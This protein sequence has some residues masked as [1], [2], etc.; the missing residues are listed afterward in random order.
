M[1]LVGQLSSRTEGSLVERGWA[2]VEGTYMQFSE[3]FDF[4]IK[5][6]TALAVRLL[7]AWKVR[8]RVLCERHG[9]P[10]QTPH[11]I[12]RLRDLV[13][14]YE[15]KINTPSNDTMTTTESLPDL[16]SDAVLSSS[17]STAPATATNATSKMDE[18]TNSAATWDQMLGFI[19]VGSISWDNFP[20]EWQ[21]AQL[22]QSFPAF[23]QQTQQAQHNHHHENGNGY[24]NGWV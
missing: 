5:P 16:K 11:Y 8:E 4:T 17:S 3:L 23:G 24:G 22:A 20:G 6:H 14:A 1:F 12:V 21:A 10:P 18:D 15:S 19:D 9:T 7:Q 2:V 13:S